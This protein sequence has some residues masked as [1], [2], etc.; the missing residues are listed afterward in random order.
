MID[1]DTAGFAV[2]RINLD[3]RI[4]FYTRYRDVF[5]LLCI[6]MVSAAILIRIPFVSFLK[7]L[8]NVTRKQNRLPSVVC[9]GGRCCGPDHLLLISDTGRAFCL[10]TF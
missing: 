6:G 8:T 1:P 7:R 2:D 4:T 9:A 5:A 3:G 10:S